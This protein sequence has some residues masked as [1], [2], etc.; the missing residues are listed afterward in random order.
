[1]IDTHAHLYEAKFEEDRDAMLSRA[2]E[3]GVEAIVIPNVDEESIAGML[4][5]EAAYPGFVYSTIGLHPCY[6]GEN[7]EAQ[8]K[9]IVAHYREGMVAVGEIGL[10]LYWDKT[11]LDRQVL[12]LDLQ[13]AFALEKDRPV[14]LHTRE[15]IPETIERIRPWAQKGLRG[16]FHCFTGTKEEAEA[17]MAMGFY[18]GIGGPVTYKS[19]DVLRS[20]L[21]S[22]DPER[23]LLE[24]D[25]PYLA[26]VPYRGKRNES[27]YLKE[28]VEVGNQMWVGGAAL[29]REASTR[30]A[31][32]LFR[33]P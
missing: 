15:A 11:T 32:T 13:C 30:G 27:A 21:S 25:A 12:A 18:L 29:W 19:N 9:A 22:L 1:M 5:I 20:V 14:I 17:I 6:V 23:V 2:R 33:L 3:A 4:A 28:I 7:P 10:D 16:V 26:P 31:K 8:V 24:T